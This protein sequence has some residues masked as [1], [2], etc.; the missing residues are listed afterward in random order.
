[1]VGINNDKHRAKE[2]TTKEG[3][4]FAKDLNAIYQRISQ[5]K[6]LDELFEKIGQKFLHPDKEEEHP[7]EEEEELQV[8]EEL[9]KHINF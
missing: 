1:M 6:D 2:V 4:S 5:K 7:D 8:F 9:N 3:I